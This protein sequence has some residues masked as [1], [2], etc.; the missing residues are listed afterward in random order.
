MGFKAC[1]GSPLI[2][3]LPVRAAHPSAK[4]YFL[5]VPILLLLWLLWVFH[6]YKLYNLAPEN[7]DIIVS[8]GPHNVLIGRIIALLR[9]VHVGKKP[10]AKLY[11]LDDSTGT[12]TETG[13]GGGDV[14]QSVYGIAWTRDGK[15]AYLGNLMNPGLSNQAGSVVKVEWPS[16]KLVKR[17]ENVTMPAPRDTPIVNDVEMTPDG[18]FLYVTDGVQGALVKIDQETD[19]I[20]KTAP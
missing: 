7:W 10:A 20:V 17:I 15:F 13:V 12:I 8:R 5:V 6:L 9:R 4:A 18:R 19:T 2:Q 16:G 11:A 1:N 3:S 14:T